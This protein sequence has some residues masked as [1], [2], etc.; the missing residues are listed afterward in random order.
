M[1]SSKLSLNTLR[2][3]VKQ[4]LFVQASNRNLLVKV[5]E[6]MLKKGIPCGTSG[7]M[8]SQEIMVDSLSDDKLYHLA[9][10]LYL[11]LSME[12]IMLDPQRYF[13]EDEVLKYKRHKYNLKNNILVNNIGNYIR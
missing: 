12:N 5:Q 2:E 4:V 6:Y 7:K 3:Q 13:E 11:G 8:Y 10:A 1:K 9:K